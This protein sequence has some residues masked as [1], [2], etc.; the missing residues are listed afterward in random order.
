MSP[1]ESRKERDLNEGASEGFTSTGIV[2]RKIPGEYWV[3]MLRAS[4]TLPK[5]LLRSSEMMFLFLFFAIY[6]SDG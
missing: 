5:F 1:C 2:N 4:L 6:K 3:P